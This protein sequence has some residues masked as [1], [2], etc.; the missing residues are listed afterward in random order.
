M[1]YPILQ[2]VY[3][4][5]ASEESSERLDREGLTAL[6][7]QS[8]SRN[9]E[10]GVTGVLLHADARFMQI[11]EGSRASIELLSEVIMKDSR[12]KDGATL[13]FEHKPNRD[14]SD[15]KM[16]YARM[17][18]GECPEG[19]VPIL[20]GYFSTNFLTVEASESYYFINTFRRQHSGPPE[21]S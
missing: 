8:R 9:E 14:F 17:N 18:N 10:L 16:R 21:T 12:H 6:L 1:P 5:T 19:Y 20:D 13:R 7:K 4:S 11:I 15:W 3:V 2:W